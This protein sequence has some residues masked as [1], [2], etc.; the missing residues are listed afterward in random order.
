[1]RQLSYARVCIEVSAKLERCEIVEVFV[2]GESFIVPIFYEWRP[3][4]CPKCHVFG[5][6]YER[7]EVPVPPAMDSWVP[8]VAEVPVPPTVESRTPTVVEPSSNT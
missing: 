7:V 5:H 1:M 3:I 2:N 8:I 6:K 4:S